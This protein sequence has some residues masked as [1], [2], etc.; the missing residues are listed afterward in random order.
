MM[1]LTVGTSVTRGPPHSPGRAVFPHPVLRLYSLSRRAKLLRS[2][3]RFAIPRSEVGSCGSSPTCP[4]RVSFAGCVL[5][6]GPSPCA[7]LSH[8]PST[9]PDKTPQGLVAVARP[10][11]AR[12]S[13][14]ALGSSLVLFPG[15]FATSLWL[16]PAG[17]TSGRSKSL[18]AILSPSVPQ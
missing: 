16:T 2:F 11:G 6:S 9:M 18:P 4:A 17:P 7:W 15:L 13:G 3:A 8:A 10:P 1:P 12:F 14:R 5:P